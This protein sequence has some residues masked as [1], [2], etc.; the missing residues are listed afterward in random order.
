LPEV[1]SIVALKK[2]AIYDRMRQGTFP[3]Q[4]KNGPRASCW[5]EVEVLRWVED[6]I[7]ARDGGV[8]GG[9]R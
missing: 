1:E 5:R 3:R 6:L 2:T 9:G 8:A 7:A 4:I